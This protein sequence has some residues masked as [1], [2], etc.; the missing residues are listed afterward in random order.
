[1]LLIASVA[2]A[3][4]WKVASP[5]ALASPQSAPTSPAGP[6]LP[7]AA[8][9]LRRE[10]QV[11]SA[12]GAALLPCDCHLALLPPL[13]KL[14]ADA[15]AATYALDAEPQQGSAV[16][17]RSSELVAG[18]AE[19]MRAPEGRICCWLKRPVAN[20]STRSSNPIRTKDVK[21]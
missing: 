8:A 13:V 20:A 17:V 9:A 19:E 16:V 3:F 18:G 6:T 12:R 21:S 1:M 7:P 5:E 10:Q 14:D 11:V 4:T 2:R 15:Q